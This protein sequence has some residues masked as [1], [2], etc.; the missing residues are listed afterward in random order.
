[1]HVQ[2]II[3]AHFIL[4]HFLV[5]LLMLALL[6]EEEE[7]KKR[8]VM[9]ILYFSSSPSLPQMHV[10]PMKEYYL[11]GPSNTVS[12]Q[13]FSINELYEMRYKSLFLLLLSSM[14]FRSIDLLPAVF[15]AF[16]VNYKGISYR[17]YTCTFPLLGS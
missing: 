8:Y 9:Y 17:V 12:V 5:L 11:C 14:P 6:Q 2:Y 16:P 13:L 1:M 15:Q 3:H 7:E 4:L 10:V